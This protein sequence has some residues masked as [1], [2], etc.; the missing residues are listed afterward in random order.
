MEEENLEN[1]S[2]KQVKDEK[3]RW[4]PGVSGNPAGRPKGAKNFTT[5]FEEAVKKLGLGEEPN[6]VEMEI[7]RKGIEMAKEGKYPF[8]KDLFD[9]IYGK[10]TEVIKLDAE[11][12]FLSE[13]EIKIK[14][15]T[16]IRGEQKHN[17]SIHQKS[18]P[19]AKPN[20]QNN[21]Q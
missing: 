13:V 1:T 17:D 19:V 3:G 20:T 18:E 14:N 2:K 12:G 10:P 15:E 4:L 16:D 7:L 5:L 6:A 11:E 21:N 8:Y 9:R